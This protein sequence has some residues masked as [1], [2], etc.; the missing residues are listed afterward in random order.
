VTAPRAEPTRTCVG[1]RGVRPKAQL[2][3][4]ALSA[5]RSRVTLDPRCRLPGRGAYLCR[6]TWAACLAAARERRG[7]SRALRV[8]DD[9]IVGSP[10]EAELRQLIEEDVP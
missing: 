2:V 3:R 1:C 8:G 6:D 10:L 9:V 5:D 4:V 7:V